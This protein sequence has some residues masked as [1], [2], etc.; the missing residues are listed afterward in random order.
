MLKE[1]TKQLIF[2]INHIKHYEKYMCQFLLCLIFFGRYI[3]SKKI[4]DVYNI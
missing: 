1:R 3:V 2:N 4:A